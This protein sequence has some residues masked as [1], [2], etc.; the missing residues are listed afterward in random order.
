MKKPLLLDLFCGQGGC[1][2]GYQLAGFETVGVDLSPQKR[3]CGD[4]F[5]QTNAVE[6]LDKIIRSGEILQYQL[7]HASPPCQ[8]FAQTRFL[9][10]RKHENLIETIRTLL[11]TSGCHYVIENVVGAPL[12]NPIMLCGAMFPDLMVYRHRLF[13]TSFPIAAP[14]H[15]K[16]IHP[17]NNMGY[18]PKDGE[19]VYVVGHFID[20]KY[21]RK[22]MGISWMER[23][24]LSQA[25]PPRYCEYVGREYLK[26][27]EIISV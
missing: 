11:L 9:N 8:L 20:V 19:F 5:I 12:I 21:A 24:G 14:E 27:Q 2:K 17:Q 13:E 22:A 25:I 15:P 18:K 16:H 23:N 7:I 26:W 1:S 10:T 6:Y 3:Y 4:K